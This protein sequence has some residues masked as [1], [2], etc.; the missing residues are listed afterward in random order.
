MEIKMIRDPSVLLTFLISAFLLLP[1]FASNKVYI[2]YLGGHYHGKGATTEDF[3][4]ATNFHQE[5]LQYFSESKEKAQEAIVYSFTKHINAFAAN[6]DEEQVAQISKHPDVISVFPNQLKK[7][8]TTRSWDFIGLERNG[9]VPPDSI[10][11][12]ANY[13]K[14][15][16][17]AHLDTGVWPESASFSDDGMGEIPVK[18]K[19]SCDNNPKS[20]VVCNRKLIGA[21]YFDKGYKSLV[22]IASNVSIGTTRDTDGHGT[23][24]L[25][26]AGGNF[27]PD[28]SLFGFANGTAKGGSPAAHVASYKVCWD[29]GCTDSDI[30][31]AFDEAIHDGV[32]VLSVSLG[33]YSF[34]YFSDSIAVGS[35][36]AMLNGI[37][38]VCSAGNDGPF[39]GFVENSA[40]WGKIVICLR[41]SI[42]RLVKG[43]AVHSAGGVGMIHVNDDD[44]E[45]KLVAD[46]YIIP[47]TMI[48]HKNGLLLQSYMNSSKLLRGT[49]SVGKTVIGVK[50]APIVARFSSRGPNRITPQVLKPDITAPGVDVLASY[51]EAIPVSES[52]YDTRRWPFNLL[53][54]TSM[55]CPH[56]AGIVGLLRKIY[57][58]WSSAAIRSAIMTTARTRD[59]IG[60]PMEDEGTRRKATP[61]AYGS[62]YIQP[63]DAMDPGLVYDL[64]IDDYMD[65]LCALGFN[66]T[67]IV[68]LLGK[69]YKCSIKKTT[70]ENLNYP[71]FAI[72]SLNKTMTVTRT[73][74][75]VGSP[76]T[77]TARI[78]AP[79]G[80][81]VSVEPQ[82]LQFKEIGEEKEFKVY[83]ESTEGSVRKGYSFGVLIWSDGKHYNLPLGFLIKA[84]HGRFFQKVEYEG[85]SHVYF[86][87]GHIGHKEKAQQA[88]VHSFTKHI[89]GF[90]AYL[91]EEQA[92]QISKHPDVLSVFPNQLKKLHTTRTWDF[93]GLERN[94]IVPPDSIWTKANYGKDVIIA[95]LD[96][97]VWPESASFS[98]DGMGEIPG[99][100]KGSCDNN[101]NSGV[102]CNRKLIGAKYY[103]KGYKSLVGIAPNVS[104]GTTRDTLGH[105]THTLS[106]AGGNFVPHASLFGFANGTAKGGSPA[107]H[108][109][110]YKVCWE[111][112]CTDSDI[113]AGFDEAINDGVDVLSV[114]L[115]GYSFDYFSD[116]VAVGSFHAMLNGIDVVCSAGNDGPTKGSVENSAPW[117]TTSTVKHNI[118]EFFSYGIR[119]CRL[120]ALDPLKVKGK[121]VICL[122]GGIDRIVKS[123]VVHN[124]GGVGMIHAIDDDVDDDVVALHI[125]PATMISHKNGLRL[126]AYVNSNKS[127]RG[128]ISA[129]KT[130]IGVKP[131]PMLAA[132]SSRGPNHITPQFLKPDITAP[133]VNVLASY[134]EAVPVS[135]PM[136]DSRRWPFKLLSGT[137]MS[138]P[139][140]AGLIGL[141]R[142]IYPHWSS[143]AIRSAIMTTARTRDNIGKPMKDEGTR[144]KATP[145]AYGSGYIQP[146]DAMDPGLV[147]DLGIDDYMDFL[148]ALGFNSTQI[149]KL[150]GKPYKCSI[151]KKTMENL[152]YP[153]F[154][155]PSLNKTMTVTR[156]VKNVGSPGT[157][158]ARIKAPEGILV[159]VEPQVLQFKE[160]GEEKEFKVYFESTEGRVRKGY[161]FGVLIWSDGKHYVRSPMA[162]KANS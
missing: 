7:L 142:K 107:A 20:G 62:G 38:V 52:K 41:G 148:C 150:L 6:L 153:S 131:A 37:A 120:G 1:V 61:F 45:D 155:I 89:N 23:H 69:P 36:H 26:T 56:V 132:F 146:N 96:T 151:K 162:V 25:S 43:L 63:N 125:I 70:M 152:N 117:V 128:T 100:W 5:F 78:K 12:K 157:Y 48:S 139:H 97:G 28:A 127:L 57:P 65:F 75:N 104:V 55:A 53:S 101:P 30:L 103:D 147:Y 44:G 8:H 82:V 18:W 59:N 74:K 94:G 16:I 40:P 115:G 137:S 105:G 113:L 154:A 88:I 66:S 76:G 138:C 79:E 60:K 77:Y 122:G 92:T 24:T 134:T 71:S 19:G 46:P 33:A 21:K 116:S 98:D 32:D 80:I 158:T 161:S 99:K 112:G 22:G 106:T 143:A 141:L 73:V 68:K 119:L 49:I 84:L 114:S 72:P 140:V 160:I 108:V 42:D 47:A 81:L 29:L 64:G 133:G 118:E 14:D 15:V 136:Y 31:A 9:I 123:L 2:V 58:H 144:R 91:D 17:I 3:D 121:I 135:E 83:F 93:M 51:T 86:H 130:I 95:H 34:D 4:Q 156:T 39:K 126:Q 13:G 35:F 90:A 102:V 11:T 149:V 111:L 85:L 50:P 54:G 10:W 67:Q 159:S 109:A 27:V 87:C 124:A 129:G 110:S 145:F